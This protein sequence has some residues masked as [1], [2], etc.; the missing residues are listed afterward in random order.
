MQACREDV[1]QHPASNDEA[2]VEDEAYDEEEGDS[3]RNDWSPANGCASSKGVH[4]DLL[5]EQPC[6]KEEEEAAH[7]TTK[8]HHM[9]VL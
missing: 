2:V 6:Q 5:E 8:L 3:G 7:Q 1:A 9:G 4:G